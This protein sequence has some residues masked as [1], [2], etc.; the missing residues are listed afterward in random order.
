MLHAT[1]DEHVT[2]QRRNSACFY[3]FE[4]TQNSRFS[5]TATLNVPNLVCLQ[6]FCSRC[7]VIE[8]IEIDCDECGNRKHSFWDDP[9][10]DMLSYLC[11]P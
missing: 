3:D 7:E 1:S 11:E 2:T 8:D 9:V 4:A 10:G 6:Q 5:K